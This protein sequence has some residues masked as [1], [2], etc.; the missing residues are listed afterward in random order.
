MEE[1]VAATEQ[2]NGVVETLIQATL[3]QETVT[4]A[5]QQTRKGKSDKGKEKLILAPKRKRPVKSVSLLKVVS[6][7][8]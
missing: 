7:D 1:N 8:Y 5:T 3:T 4:R 6:F 2:T